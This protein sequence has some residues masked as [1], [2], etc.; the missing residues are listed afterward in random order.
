MKRII[1]AAAAFATLS[2]TA[3]QAQPAGGPAPNLDV[4]R[5]G[6]VTLAEFKAAQDQRQ[7]RMFGRLD[8]NKDGKIIQA[9]V[10]AMAK[11]AAAAGRPAQGAGQG[12]GQGGGGLM[13]MDA[14]RDGA[15]TRAEMAALADR[16][17]K[18]ADT[19]SDGWLSK[20]EVLMIQQRMRG[21]P[22]PQ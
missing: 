18:M 15:V 3:A 2:V 17:F 12:G 20:G 7:R 5:D 21:G 14:N 4:D 16:R 22:G 8:A 1:I 19:N 10:D 9:E 13:R 11:R 6:K